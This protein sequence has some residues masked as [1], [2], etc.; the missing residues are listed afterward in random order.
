[1][2]ADNQKHRDEAQN[3]N[4]GIHG[5][6]IAHSFPCKNTRVIHLPPTKGNNDGTVMVGSRRWQWKYGIGNPHGN[7]LKNPQIGYL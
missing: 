5:R 4:V 6:A 2:K 7:M 3:L 1:M